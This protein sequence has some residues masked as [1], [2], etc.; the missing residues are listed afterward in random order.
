M[1]SLF[2][3]LLGSWAG[4]C[5]GGGVLIDLLKRI[6]KGRL[7]NPADLSA[8]LDTTPDLLDQMLGDLVQ[9]GYLDPV[10]AVCNPASCSS[11]KGCCA[12]SSGSTGRILVLTEKGQRAV[13][14]N[15]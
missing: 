12:A 3:S 9:M 15:A 10:A 5:E 4:A 11:C 2:I 8:A 1:G 6:A 7:Y 13:R 14:A